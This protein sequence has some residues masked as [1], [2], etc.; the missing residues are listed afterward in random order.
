MDKFVRIYHQKNVNQYF[1]G[2]IPSAHQPSGIDYDAK[3]KF[4][5]KIRKS[6]LNRLF[7]QVKYVENQEKLKS[8]ESKIN[9][10]EIF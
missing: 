1:K 10:K 2:L 3:R 5:N 9:N 4:S 8:E 6:A 7:E